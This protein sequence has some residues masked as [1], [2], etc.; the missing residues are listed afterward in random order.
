MTGFAAAGGQ[1]AAVS[2]LGGPPAG[3]ACAGTVRFQTGA[4]F[5]TSE[6]TGSYAR[7]AA[8]HAA[9]IGMML[10]ATSP[11][12]IASKASLIWLRS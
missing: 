9:L 10:R 11:F 4:A 6:G 1:C 8:V 7:R 3:A 2:G 12:F 5:P